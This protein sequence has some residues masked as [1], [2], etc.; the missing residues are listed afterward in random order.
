MKISSVYP[1]YPVQQ[2]QP[3]ARTNTFEQAA[4]AT[5]SAKD[6]LAQ[7]IADKQTEN[8]T[9]IAGVTLAESELGQHIDLRV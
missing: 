2:T 7:L 9:A 1:G 8:S 4:E 3:T 5:L 6:K